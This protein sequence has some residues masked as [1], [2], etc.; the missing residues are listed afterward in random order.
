[1]KPYHFAVIFILS[2]FFLVLGVTVINGIHYDY[3]FFADDPGYF[4]TYQ[5]FGVLRGVFFLYNHQ[6]G[7]LL[8]HLLTLSIC[9]FI[10]YGHAFAIVGLYIINIIIIVTASAFFFRRFA[11]FRYNIS[12]TFRRSLAL[13]LLIY[14]VFFLAFFEKRFEWW[15]W[16]SSITV[17]QYSLVLM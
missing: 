8:S 2:L 10:L 5:N 16:L 3:R 7:R 12:L 9:P 1:M 11:A 14:S 17:Y 15:F 13:S 6:N 4:K